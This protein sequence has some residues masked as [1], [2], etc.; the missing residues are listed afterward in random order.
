VEFGRKVISANERPS[1]QELD[2]LVRQARG[3]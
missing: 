2:K 1:F 3:R